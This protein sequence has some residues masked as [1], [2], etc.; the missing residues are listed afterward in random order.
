MCTVKAH[1]SG[2]FHF[3]DGT[4]QKVSVGDFIKIGQIVGFIEVAEVNNAVIS[5]CEGEI[6][7]IV[8]EEDEPIEDSNILIAFL[9]E[10]K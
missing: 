4:I 3:T 9:I 8:V 10:P 6:E 5:S 7:E 2:I 1:M